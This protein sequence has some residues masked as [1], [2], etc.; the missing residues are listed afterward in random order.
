MK[1]LRDEDFETVEL[2]GH[3]FGQL[4]LFDKEN[5]IFFCADQVIDG[6]VRLLQQHIR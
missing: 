6:I 4:G 1:Y 2:K 5:K 3:T